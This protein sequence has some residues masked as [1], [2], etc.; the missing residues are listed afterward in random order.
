V[1]FN[2]EANWEL[3]IQLRLGH[4]GA[5]YECPDLAGI[6]EGAGIY[7]FGR[8]YGGRITPFYVGR[9]ENLRCRI[10]QQFNSVKL[11]TNIREGK[12]GTRFLIYCQPRPRRGQ[13]I[14]RVIRIMEESLIAY[15]LSQGYELMQKQGLKRPNHTLSFRGNRTSEG[16]IRRFMRIRA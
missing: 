3:P 6:P 15:I 9:A 2:I 1:P 11:M 10:K 7:I 4:T 16:I 13:P 14:K 8:N 12:T 5:I